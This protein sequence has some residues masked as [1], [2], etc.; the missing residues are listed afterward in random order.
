MSNN[1]TRAPNGYSG[2]DTGRVLARAELYGAPVPYDEPDNRPVPEDATLEALVETVFDAVEKAFDGS[3]LEQEAEAT[4][5]SL[6]YAFHHQVNRLQGLLDD[7]EERI[8]AVR[9]DTFDSSDEDNYK[10]EQLKER[11]SYI[12]ERRDAME[13]LRDFSK[14]AYHERTGKVWSVRK[15]AIANHRKMT[16]ST[17][18]A[19]RFLL[20]KR[21][22]ETHTLAPNGTLIAFSGGYDCQDVNAIWADLDAARAKYPDMIL[23]HTAGAKGADAIAKAWCANRGVTEVPFPMRKRNADD[24]AAPF[25]RNDE[26]L[27]LCPKGVIVYAGSGITDN[28]ADKAR[29]KGIIVLDRR[30]KAKPGA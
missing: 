30:N 8:R 1:N 16:A 2:L 22:R 23:A 17:V 9:G 4:L 26:L 10:L 20:A 28:L 3:G 13:Q 27:A 18:D 11:G 6:T 29:A 21:Y 14:D 12:E 5:S 25:R 24:R 7:N 19:D 15:G